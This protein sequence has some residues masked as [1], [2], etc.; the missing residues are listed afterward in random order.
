MARS[1]NFDTDDT[2]DKAIA[3]FGK[4]GYRDTTPAQLV[5]YLGISRSSLY[6]TY[7]D[8]QNLYLKALQRYSARVEKQFIAIADQAEDARQGIRDYL[9]LSLDGCFGEDMQGG[10][11]LVN[12]IAELPSG[13]PG[14]M[15]IIAESTEK[16]KKILLRLLKKA[17]K[18]GQLSADFNS[19]RLADYLMNAVTGLTI[20]AK[21]GVSKKV[22]QQILDTTLSILE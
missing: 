17:Q 4:Q 10:C 6:D 5:E 7:G 12:S 18:E 3:L 15:A 1:K 22:C 13:E 21:S 9:Q 14:L 11:F 19:T 2:L 20:S 8:K 16:N